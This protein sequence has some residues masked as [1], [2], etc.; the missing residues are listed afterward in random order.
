MRALV[1]CGSRDGGFTSEMC[2][3]FAEG[4]ASRGVASGV[5]FPIDMDIRHCTGCGLCSADGECVIADG[6]GEVYEAFRG[7]DLLALASPTRFSGPSSAIKTVIDRFQPAW[8]KDRGHPGSA[9]GLLSG[10]SPSPRFSNTVS[11]FKALAATTGM[12]WLG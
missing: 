7:S 6:M 10:G 11:V 3:S 1:V 5:I 2:R 8:F 12:E 9:V 4:L